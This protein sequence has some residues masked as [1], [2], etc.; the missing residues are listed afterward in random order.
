MSFGVLLTYTDIFGRAK[1]LPS[2]TELTRGIPSSTMIHYLSGVNAL[3]FIVPIDL[4]NQY[5]LFRLI[6]NRLDDYEKNQLLFRF[7]KFSEVAKPRQIAIFSLYTVLN[8]IIEELSN[9]KSG[10]FRNI[11]PQEE[12]NI[13]SKIL[14]YNEL[15]DNRLLNEISKIKSFDRESYYQIIWPLLLPQIEFTYRK[16]HLF[17]IYKSIKFLKF[18]QVT[19]KYQVFLDPFFKS[20]NVQDSNDFIIQALLLFKNA[21]I[22]EDK[23]FTSFLKADYP[24]YNPLINSF[25]FDFNEKVKIT[26]DD[27]SDFKLLRNHPIIRLPDKTLAITNWNFIV[28]KLYPGLIYD[29]FNSTDIKNSYP[30]RD[31]KPNI[32]AYL[33]EIGSQFAEEEFLRNHLQTILSQNLQVVLP[34]VNK[35]NYD[36]YARDGKHVFLIEFKNISMPKHTQYKDIKDYIDTR[37]VQD[38]KSR[39]GIMQLLEQIK[40]LNDNPSQFENF[41]AQ[42]TNTRRLVVHP[43]LVFTDNS[44]NLSGINSYLNK[45]FKDNLRLIIPRVSFYVHDLVIIPFDFFLESRELLISREI[46]MIYLINYYYARL[47]KLRKMVFKTKSNFYNLYSPFDEVVASYLGKKKRKTPSNSYFEKYI[48]EELFNNKKIL[49][50]SVLKDIKT[51]PQ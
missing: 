37:L 46:S 43:V 29:F 34:G 40:K 10:E 19:K 23:F 41:I 47:F 35:S 27:S 28:D 16:N 33:S 15:Q 26:S 24:S 1:D 48:K 20:L 13:F 39:K 30:L 38:G 50:Q 6:I 22:K 17:A 5:N 11:S 2:T 25:I 51:L 18:L 12:I 3:N 32:N 7:Y 9:F 21:H 49:P 36:L 4:R 45:I 42:G 44:F 8:C 31:G 14:I